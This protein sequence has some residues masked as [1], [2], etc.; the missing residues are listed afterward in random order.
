[1]KVC[2]GTSLLSLQHFIIVLMVGVAIPKPWP[3][4][5]FMQSL[6]SCLFL[7]IEIIP[8]LLLLWKIVIHFGSNQKTFKRKWATQIRKYYRKID[9][10]L[11]SKLTFNKWFRNNCMSI[12]LKNKPY[13][14]PHY[15]QSW[16]KIN[17]KCKI[18]KDSKRR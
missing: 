2:S 9:P 11:Y 1:M 3:Q 10:H 12:F 18:Y 5:H 13:P 15:K 6:S 4:M 8:C 14:L 7:T 16:L 17:H